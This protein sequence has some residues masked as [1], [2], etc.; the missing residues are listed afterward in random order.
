MMGIAGFKTKKELKAAV[1]ETPSFIETSFFGAEFK[2]DGSYSV[3]GP[4]PYT[5]RNWYAT[6]VVKDGKIAKVV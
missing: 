5:A 3:V 6:V 1:G 2:G 4:D